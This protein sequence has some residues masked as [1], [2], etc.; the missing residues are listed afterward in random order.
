M[1]SEF[2]NNYAASLELDLFFISK[3]CFAIS[4]FCLGVL[5]TD[6]LSKLLYLLF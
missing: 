1:L 2:E 3:D 4:E 5:G 6:E